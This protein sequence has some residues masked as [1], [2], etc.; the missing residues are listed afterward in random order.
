MNTLPMGSGVRAIGV[1]RDGM[2]SIGHTRLPERRTILHVGAA[3][4]QR[5]FMAR[6][7][8]LYALFVNTQGAA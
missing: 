4:Q 6:N 8:S 7:H 3:G 2:L 5:H 1:L